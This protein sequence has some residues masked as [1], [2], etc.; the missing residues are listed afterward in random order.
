[1]IVLPNFIIAPNLAA[2]GA[3]NGEENYLC[4]LAGMSLCSKD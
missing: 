2:I 1:M 3:A 4:N